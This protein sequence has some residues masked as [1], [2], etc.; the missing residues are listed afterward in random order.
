MP[1]IP[2]IPG[3]PKLPLIPLDTSNTSDMPGDPNASLPG[4]GGPPPAAALG[5]SYSY[6][7][8]PNGTLTQAMRGSHGILTPVCMA[9]VMCHM[10][11]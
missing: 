4:P 8:R 3:L 9:S 7:V 5:A 6:M 11:S 10:G 2:V 1:V